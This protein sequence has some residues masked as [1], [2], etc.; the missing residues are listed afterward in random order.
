[1]GKRYQLGIDRVPHLRDFVLRRRSVRMSGAVTQVWDTGGTVFNTTSRLKSLIEAVTVE[2]VQ[3]QAVLA[4]EALGFGIHVRDE[5]LVKAVDALSGH[6]NVRWQNLKLLIGIRSGELHKT[7]RTSRSLSSFFLFVCAC[8]ICFTD[9]EIGDLALQMILAS[10]VM[11]RY[12]IASYQLGD[13]IKSFSGHAESLAP[14]SMMHALAVKMDQHSPE[15]IQLYRRLNLKELGTLLVRSFEL[16]NDESIDSITLLGGTNG[17]LLATIFSWL[18]PGKV[19]ISIDGTMLSDNSSDGQMSTGETKNSKLSLQ[20]K[21]SFNT[22]SYT[23]NWIIRE[24]RKGQP[25]EFV[26]EDNEENQSPM[27]R[28]IP[29]SLAKTFLCLLYQPQHREYQEALKLRVESVLGALASALIA[30]LSRSGSLYEPTNCCENL[31]KSCAVSRLWDVLPE[32]WLEVYDSAIT[33]YGWSV[34]ATVVGQK[35]AL[36]LLE[37]AFQEQADRLADHEQ[38]WERVKAIAS[39]FIVSEL[40]EDL[41]EDDMERED[42]IF[43]IFDPAAYVATNAVATATCDFRSGIQRIAPPSE[44]RWG[45]AREFFGSLLSSKGMKIGKFREYSF[46]KALPGDISFDANDVVIC[47]NGYTAGISALWNSCNTRKRNALAVRVCAGVI[48]RDKFRFDS[49]REANTHHVCHL[50][51]GDLIQIKLFDGTDYLGLYPESDQDHLRVEHLLGEAGRQLELKSYLIASEK[52]INP[53][54]WTRSIHGLVIAVHFE[55]RTGH[56]ERQEKELAQTHAASLSQ[57]FW[58]S[59]YKWGCDDIDAKTIMKTSGNEQLRFFSCGVVQSERQPYVPN[60]CFKI[61]LRHSA[62]LMSSV[63]AA[64][65]IADSWV[66][67][68]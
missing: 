11:K 63:L 3:P 9:A 59:L 10:G 47:S 28:Y 21:N 49:I 18:V 30:L 5:L 19:S 14:A 50:S 22:G 25:T 13:L 34:S 68:C 29:L 1:M 64:E 26:V 15:S 24:W 37:P 31:D 35:K 17:L 66:V 60:G 58:R 4:A 56:T 55:Q 32:R 54:S 65:N 46:V 45:S 43:A 61:V 42:Q 53:V 20:L 40:G 48:E 2:N 39:D 62:S 36:G 52:N 51:E 57:A 38:V 27:F 23:N 16:L 67:I 7:I 41:S 33:R 8:K 44:V 12:P 6:E